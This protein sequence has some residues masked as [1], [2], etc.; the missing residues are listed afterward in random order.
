MVAQ[1]RATPHTCSQH[2]VLTVVMDPPS[3][4]LSIMTPWSTSLLVGA[5]QLLP[6]QPGVFAVLGWKSYEN[7]SPAR[8]SGSTTKQLSVLHVLGHHFLHLTLALLPAANSDMCW[9]I[10][11]KVHSSNPSWASGATTHPH[12]RATENREKQGCTEGAKE[13]TDW[14]PEKILYN[15]P[16][17]QTILQREGRLEL[18]V[19]DLHIHVLLRQEPRPGPPYWSW[20]QTDNRPQCC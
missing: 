9:T 6:K 5:E 16:T 2:G 10:P 19:Q 18:E 12:H 1:I 14:I 11:E 15:Y 4:L 3:V 8:L 7:M 13:N 17:L 20:G